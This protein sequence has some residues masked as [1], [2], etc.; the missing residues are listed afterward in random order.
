MILHGIKTKDIKAVGL[1]KNCHKRVGGLN[2]VSGITDVRLLKIPG[3]VEE[4]APLPENTDLTDWNIPEAIL[5]T[6]KSE[7]PSSD[8]ENNLKWGL[9]PT[10][11][12]F[13]MKPSMIK[14]IE[15]WKIQKRF[16]AAGRKIGVNMPI[17]ISGPAAPGIRR[18]F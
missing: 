5:E 8:E 1:M 11:A 14:E 17:T 10:P 16:A 7:S 18:K 6:R 2:N 13:L 3:T 9:L 12:D 15:N 4:L